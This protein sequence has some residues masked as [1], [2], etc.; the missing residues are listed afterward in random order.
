MPMKKGTVPPR[1]DASFKQ[2]AVKMVTEQSKTVKEVASQL[3]ICTD[4]LR[5]W[6]KQSGFNP[7]ETER[8]NRD[9]KHQRELEVEI[10]ALRKQLAEKDEVIS[11]LKKSVGILS[12]P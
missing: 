5:T 2:G 11:I 10:R 1:Y 3:G 4:T 9:L 7:G 6:L 12:T 8:Q